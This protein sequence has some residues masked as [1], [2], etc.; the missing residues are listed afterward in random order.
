[1]RFLFLSPWSFLALASCASTP[2]PVPEA[3]VAASASAASET[4]SIL[5]SWVD[6]GGDL[7]RFL[8]EGRFEAPAALAG[9]R[10]AAEACEEA[11]MD[12]EACAEPRF[13]WLG[14]PSDDARFLIAMSMPMMNRTE[15]TGELMCFCP[16]DPGLPFTAMLQGNQLVL[17]A[18][19]PNG[20][21]I[22]DGSFSLTR[23]ESSTA[24]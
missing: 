20:A 1:M 14:H 18:L 2:T 21:P 22:P 4:P 10:R 11:G 16:P 3:P 9:A 19:Q 24:P 5:G 13:R 8:E 15:A 6:E 17:N 23:S 12:V 7:Y